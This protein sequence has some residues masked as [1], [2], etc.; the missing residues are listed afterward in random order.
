MS[1][2]QPKEGSGALFPND[3]QGNANRPDWRGDVCI[4]GK[5]YELSGWAKEGRR[6]EFIS[7]SA[8]PKQDRQSTSTS[9]RPAAPSRP[10]P[11]DFGDDNEPPF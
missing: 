2:H 3:K 5:V 10:P 8:K 11:Q 1:D 6:S 4:E 9:A 7:L